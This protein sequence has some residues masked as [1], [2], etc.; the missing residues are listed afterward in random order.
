VA[1]HYIAASKMEGDNSTE[2][3]MESAGFSD[4]DGVHAV[5]PNADSVAAEAS[6]L[7]GVIGSRMPGLARGDLVHSAQCVYTLT[8]DEHL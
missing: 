3:G 2:N 7:Q 5:V 4:Q 6:L 1:R 8:H